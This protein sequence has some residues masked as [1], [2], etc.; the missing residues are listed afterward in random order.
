M[1]VLW[2]HFQHHSVIVAISIVASNMVSLLA[3]V[4]LLLCKA[5]RVYLS[6]ATCLGD[7]RHVYY[8]LLCALQYTAVRLWIH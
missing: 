2:H 1:S 8:C 5:V 4:L 6:S 7:Q 3:M